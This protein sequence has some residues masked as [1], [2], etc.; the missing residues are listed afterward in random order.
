MKK[1]RMEN[2][3]QVMRRQGGAIL[4]NFWPPMTCIFSSAWLH[5]FASFSFD[6]DWS[7]QSNVGKLFSE[8]K[9]VTDNLLF[10]VDEYDTHLG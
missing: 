7:L 3:R 8:L 6:E 5:G 4:T 9:L 1:I 2:R 10:N